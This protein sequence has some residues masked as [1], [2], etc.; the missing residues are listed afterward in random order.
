MG[1]GLIFAGQLLEL[2]AAE[3]VGLVPCA[4]GGTCLDKW[5]P[6]ADL[7]Q[8]MASPHGISVQMYA[9]SLVE[10]SADRKLG[11]V[12]V[13]RTHMAMQSMPQCKLRGLLWYQVIVDWA[14]C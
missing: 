13:A 8:Q 2:D 6:G 7:Y 1:P 10:Q 4:V 9:T 5:Q 12:Q 11:A 14:P 3:R